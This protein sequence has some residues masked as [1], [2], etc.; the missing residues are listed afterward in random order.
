[1]SVISV[2]GMTLMPRTSGTPGDEIGVKMEF[3]PNAFARLLA[4]IAHGFFMVAELGD[5]EAYLPRGILSK[6]ESVGRWVG[7]APDQTVE[8]RG[9][10]GVNLLRTEAGEIHVRVRLFLQLGGPEHLVVAGR[11]LEPSKRPTRIVAVRC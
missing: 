5:V 1:M 3:G 7:G 2:S 4:K 6:G 8:G 9:L 11:V 10:H